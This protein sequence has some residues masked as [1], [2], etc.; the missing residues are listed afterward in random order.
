MDKIELYTIYLRIDEDGE[1]NVG[2]EVNGDLA[3]ELGLSI[4]Y[5]ESKLNNKLGSSLSHPFLWLPF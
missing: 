4:E 2:M 3:E 1:A 5:L